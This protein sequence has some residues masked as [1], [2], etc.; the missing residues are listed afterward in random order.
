MSVDPVLPVIPDVPSYVF[1]P[2]SESIYA[3]VF[4]LP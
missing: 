3:P 1:M 4:T 2:S